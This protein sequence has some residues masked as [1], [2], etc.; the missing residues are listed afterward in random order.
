M[1]WSSEGP[2]NTG[3]TN[4]T[5]FTIAFSVWI[6][7]SL[8]PGLLHIKQSNSCRQR[9]KFPTDHLLGKNVWLPA[10]FV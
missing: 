3:N 5:F 2:E 1:C 8:L 6:Q 4:K 7:R 9:E 10:K